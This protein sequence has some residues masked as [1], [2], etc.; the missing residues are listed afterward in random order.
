MKTLHLKRTDFLNSKCT[1]GTLTLDGVEICKTLE[2]PYREN[3]VR[4]SCIP[5]GEYICKRYR[6]PRFPSKRQEQL[7]IKYVFELL[8]VPNRT[9]ILIHVGN[10]I[11]DTEGCILV[12][13][14][15]F[16]VNGIPSLTNSI[17]ALKKLIRIIGDDTQFKLVISHD[18]GLF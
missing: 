16:V 17:I 10:Y 14:S 7:G 3:K 18:S 4:I 1:I 9:Y 13:E 12:G 11:K 5:S 15:Q 8:D 6:S 2:L